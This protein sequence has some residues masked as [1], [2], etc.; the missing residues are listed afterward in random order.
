MSY[1]CKGLNLDENEKID[2]IRAAQE[3]EAFYSSVIEG[4]HTTKKRT[5][6]LVEKGLEPKNKDERMVLNNYKA[7]MFILENLHRDIDEDIII[8][9]YQ[10][11]TEGTLDEEELG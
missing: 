6:E 8:K 3:D 4:A 9:I 2:L 7:L 10:K 1:L 5:K 11:V